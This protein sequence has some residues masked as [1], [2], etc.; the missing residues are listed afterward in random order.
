MKTI[1]IIIISLLLSALAI[2]AYVVKDGPETYVYLGKQTPK[3]FK[4]SINGLSLL[5]KDENIQFFYSDAIIDIQ[6]GMYIIT[7][8]KIVLYSREWETPKPS[9]PYEQIGRIEVH[10][11]TSWDEDTWVF[12]SDLEGQPLDF[13]LS[14]EKGTDQKVLNYIKAKIKPEAQVVQIN[15]N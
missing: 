12:L 11:S 8:K 14:P 2:F 1:S 9:I 10:Y 15:G 5:E 13:P 7:D 6:D 3:E 4:Q